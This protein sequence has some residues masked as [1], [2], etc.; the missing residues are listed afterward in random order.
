MKNYIKVD[1]AEFKFATKVFSR[2]QLNHGRVL[3]AYDAGFLT[4]ESGEVT[5]VMRAK[6]EWHGRATFSSQIMHALAIVPPVQ[7]P[8]VIAYKKDHLLIGGMKIICEWHKVSQ[9]FIQKLENPGVLDLLAMERNLPRI[10]IIGTPL[11]ER[12]KKAMQLSERRIM[13]AAVQLKELEITELEIRDLVEMRIEERLD[14]S[15]EL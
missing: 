5:A 7:N 6:G 15:G 11:G 12:I 13:K 1:A 8:V 9:E 10:D 4:I 3:L 14:L 2:K